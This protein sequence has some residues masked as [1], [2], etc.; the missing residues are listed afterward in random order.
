MGGLPTSSSPSAQAVFA[1]RL[2]RV[3]AER[4]FLDVDYNYLSAGDSQD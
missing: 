2:V 3:L 1:R 4:P